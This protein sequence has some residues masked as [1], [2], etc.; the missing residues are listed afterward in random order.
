MAEEVG[1]VSE[2]PVINQEGGLVPVP[3]QAALEQVAAAVV[4]AGALQELLAE[5]EARVNLANLR[6][7]SVRNLK[8]ARLRVLAASPYPV[9]MEAL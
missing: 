6:E 8:C 3:G 7:L 9:G 5:G 2:V 1:L 4:R